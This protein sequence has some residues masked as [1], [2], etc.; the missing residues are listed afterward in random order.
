MNQRET[1]IW[2]RL[3]LE[4]SKEFVRYA[5]ENLVQMKSKFLVPSEY[6]PEI[7]NPQILQT[8]PYLRL[9]SNTSLVAGL[10]HSIQ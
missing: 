8:L 7:S 2:L 9:V 1:E 6:R 5:M 10:A 4:G 3:N